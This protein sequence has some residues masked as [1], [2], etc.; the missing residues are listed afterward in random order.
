MHIENSFQILRVSYKH[1]KGKLSQ[2]LRVF[3]LSEQIS[4]TSQ[5]VCS[6]S[7]V[8]TLLIFV[9]L[10]AYIILFLVYIYYMYHIVYF[11]I[12]FIDYTFIKQFD[13]FYNS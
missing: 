9:I 4:L 6:S 10:Y 12:S 7:V 5:V 3:A 2:N 1:P 11:Y 8:F 13:L